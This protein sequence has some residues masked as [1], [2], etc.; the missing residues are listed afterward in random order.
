MPVVFRTPIFARATNNRKRVILVS[1]PTRQ[2]DIGILYPDVEVLL[3]MDSGDT[4]PYRAV[5]T[6]VFR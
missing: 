4:A 1:R 6:S 3:L 2:S 5:A